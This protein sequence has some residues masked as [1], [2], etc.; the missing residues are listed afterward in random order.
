MI[1]VI[2]IAINL[3]ADRAI[4]IGIE[5]AATKA[6]DVGVDVK[7]VDLSIL[8]GSLSLQELVINNPPGYAHDNLLVLN[9][10]RVAVN[11]KSLMSDTVNIKEIKLDGV[12]IVMEQ[13]GLTSNLQDIIKNI[14]KKAKPEEKL[15]Q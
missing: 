9:K 1:L 10:A 11:I 5:T 7:D 6:L 2:I 4:K 8:G 12:N 13:K 15:D 14:Q 3:F